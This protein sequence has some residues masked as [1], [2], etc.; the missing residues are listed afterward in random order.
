MRVVICGAGIAGLAMAQR[1]HSHGWDVVVVERSPGPREQGYMID[2]FGLGYDAAE[3]MGVLP[4]L[5][6]LGYYLPE[7]TFVD[8]TGR[9]RAGISFKSFIRYTNGRML[10]IMRPDL[11]LA[12]RE[13][14]IG[15]VDL[16][17]GVSVTDIADFGEGVRVTLSDGAAVEAD[18]LVG[19]D[20][21]HST[22]RRQ[23]FG[24]GFLRY[25]G[26]HTAAY[27]FTDA[28]LH[29]LIGD[30]FI[31]TDTTNRQMGFYSLRDGR[32]A[33]FAVHRTPDPTLP[34]DP[35]EEIQRTYGSLGWIVPD[36]VA[37]CPPPDRVYYDQV[38]QA[39]VPRWSRGRVVLLGDACQAVSLLAGQ[40]AT[41]AIAG[42]YVLGEHLARATTIRDALDGYEQQWRPV[43]T[44]KQRVG[45]N[46]AE[47]FLPSTRGRLF[48][49]RLA[50]RTARLPLLDAAYAAS[51]AGRADPSLDELTPR[52]DGQRLQA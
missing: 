42:A 5:Q 22:V 34:A 28:R 49:R 32:V 1:I 19:A 35:G 41:L 50:M 14:V 24:D 10:S 33:I 25:L 31:M 44:E 18:L 9:R 51:L 2:F 52:L 6:E 11:E 21:I 46:T 12:L 45:R 40:G 3:T 20:G 36:A 29:K 23:V 48:A 47:W 16:R 15:Q 13:K 43:V 39:I 38:A 7:A 37:S 17:F 30:R 8:E 26:F 27:T 4:R